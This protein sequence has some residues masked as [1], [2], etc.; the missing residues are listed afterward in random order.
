MKAKPLQ[1][2]RRRKK[3]W[4]RNTHLPK[5][6]RSVHQNARSA[7]PPSRALERPILGRRR[8]LLP[9]ARPAAW[10]L[11]PLCQRHCCHARTMALQLPESWSD[12]LVKVLAVRLAVLLG[13]S[14][15]L[16]QPAAAERRLMGW[17]PG[18]WRGPGRS[19]P[20]PFEVI[21]GRRPRMKCVEFR[22]KHNGP[23]TSTYFDR[24]SPSLPP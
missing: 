24:P 1:A 17:P 16:A 13:R 23:F 9:R 8:R 19:I 14:G 12:A 2:R 20:C 15:A 3:I 11:L 7:M 22:D 10:L 4:G 21:Q 18:T 6:R 5:N